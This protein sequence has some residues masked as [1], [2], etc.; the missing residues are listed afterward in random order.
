[1]EVSRAFVIVVSASRN[2]GIGANGGIPWKL[3]KDLAHFKA[4]TID[5]AVIMGRKTWDALPARVRP[6]PGRE[7]IVVTSGPELTGA[8]TFPS[9][10][11]AINSA[12]SAKI[13]VIGGSYLFQ[14][15]FANPILLDACS[16]IYLTRLA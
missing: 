6:L 15:I 12:E 13:S 16:H 10:A 14:E 2:F 11:Q 1:M 7:N 9:L 3:P 5:G 8:K 4:V